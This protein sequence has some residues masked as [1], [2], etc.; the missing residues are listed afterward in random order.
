MSEKMQFCTF[1]LDDHLYGIEV[2]RVQEVMS[3]H[4]ITHLPARDATVRGLLNLRGQIV[5]VVDLRQS[6]GLPAR[7]P[8]VEPANVVVRTAEGAISLW[9]D[10]IGDVVEVSEE[11]FERPPATLSARGGELV[12]G[13][14][15]LESRLLLVLDIARTLQSATV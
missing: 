1:L 14:Y 10:E 2:G 6:L 3:A 15:K 4:T 11:S 7:A 12:R 13:A 5:P 9:V 8:G